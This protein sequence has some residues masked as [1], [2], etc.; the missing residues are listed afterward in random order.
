MRFLV[1][2]DDTDNLESRGT[3]YR[4]RQLA[5]ALAHRGMA[6]RG[7]TRHQ[8]LVDPRIPYTS[9]NSSAC[10]ELEASDNRLGEVVAICREFLLEE[11]APG[12]DAG[13]C[14]A[15]LQESGAAGRAF[16]VPHLEEIVDFGRR[17]KRTVVTAAEAERLAAARRLHL[18]GL[19]GTRIGVIG[20]LAAVGLR[21][22]ADDGRFLWMPRLRDLSGVHTAA[23]L[24]ETLGLDAIETEQ[25]R[26]VAGGDR[27]DLGEWPRPLLR[28]G[29]SV[30][31]V[32]EAGCE[33]Y[34][35]VVTAKERIKQLSE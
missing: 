23:S 1:G 17:A 19:T 9:H 26:A 32:Q 14:V 12:S 25:G 11:S 6:P 18:E 15:E 24:R 21:A 7:V 3:G 4:A 8:L 13:L 35:W 5:A 2:I 10:I 29:R 20:A 28:H 16:A 31:L 33:D 27:I 34:E 30:L 22:G